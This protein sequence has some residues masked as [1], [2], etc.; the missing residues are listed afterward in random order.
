[1]KKFKVV[2]YPQPY[3]YIIK[4]KNKKEAEEKVIR[5]EWPDEQDIY[6]IITARY[7]G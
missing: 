5:S 2:I 7:L 3:E 1:M 6:K 4:A